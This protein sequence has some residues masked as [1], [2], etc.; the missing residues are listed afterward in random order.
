MAYLNETYFLCQF[1][2]GLFIGQAEQAIDVQEKDVSQFNYLPYLYWLY[3]V[4]WAL[5]INNNNNK[6][7]NDNC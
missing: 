3:T 2:L 7:Q 1:N 6:N 5:L 4:S